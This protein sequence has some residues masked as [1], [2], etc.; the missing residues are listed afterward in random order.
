MNERRRSQRTELQSKLIMKRLDGGG[1]L[2]VAIEVNDISRSGVGFIC[3]TPLTI[4]A[5]FESY[6]TIWTKEVLHSFLQI[7]RIEMLEN[8]YN[9]GASFVGMPEV[10]ASRI[11]VYQ[12]FNESK[13]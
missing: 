9:Y 13:K 3:D 7:V 1:D 10:D 5:V 8:G 6:L 12:A 4:G 2:E 11:E